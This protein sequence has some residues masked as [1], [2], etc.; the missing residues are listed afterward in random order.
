[1]IEYLIWTARSHE[2]PSFP[3]RDADVLV[4]AGSGCVPVEG[5]GDFRMRCGGTEVAFS[6]EDPGWQV[7]FEGPMPEQDCERLVAALTRQ[8][9][10]AAGETCEWIRIT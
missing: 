1:V 3:G 6:A 5:W 2:L 8:I 7:I 4:P 9:E 10:Q